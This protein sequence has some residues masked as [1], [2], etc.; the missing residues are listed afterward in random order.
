MKYIPIKEYNCFR[1]AERLL[2]ALLINTKSEYCIDKPQLLRMF[3]R[4]GE[5]GRS[6]RV[7]I[8]E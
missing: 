3:S 8:F 6:D 5:L 7:C 1:L 4:S 2:H